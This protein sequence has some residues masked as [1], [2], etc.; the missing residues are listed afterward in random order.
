MVDSAQTPR[1]YQDTSLF[2][3]RHDNIIVNL[4]YQLA[5]PGSLPQRPKKFNEYG[6]ATSIVLNT[7]NVTKTPNT[8]VYQYDVS[9]PCSCS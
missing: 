5:V 9:L 1:F 8:V 7:F 2:R 3:P 4:D 6:K